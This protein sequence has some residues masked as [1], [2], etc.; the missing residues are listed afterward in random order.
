MGIV[1]HSAEA[2]E[3]ESDLWALAKA[4]APFVTGDLLA[5][6]RAFAAANPGRSIAARAITYSYVKGRLASWF[7]RHWLFRDGRGVTNDAHVYTIRRTRSPFPAFND[8]PAR[9]EYARSER[10]YNT[11]AGLGAATVRELMTAAPEVWAANAKLSAEAVAHARLTARLW[12][13]E[14]KGL[15][16]IVNPEARRTQRR[17]E[18]TRA[19]YPT[20]DETMARVNAER[21]VRRAKK[22]SAILP[23]SLAQARAATWVRGL[24]A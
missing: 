15:I 16:R 5:A 1:W 18:A 22:P 14:R 6:A 17:Y 4:A 12:N 3:A 24:V 10:C 9:A 2:H 11:L 7:S 20:Y 23:R 13:W 8:A 21:G 19:A